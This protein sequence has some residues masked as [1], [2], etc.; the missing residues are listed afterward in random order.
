MGLLVC[1]QQGVLWKK[2]EGKNWNFR[3]FS[4]PTRPIWNT[5][6]PRS[7]FLTT[8]VLRTE[9]AAFRSLFS[10]SPA[11]MRTENFTAAAI[12]SVCLCPG[13]GVSFPQTTFEHYRRLNVVLCIEGREVVRGLDSLT[14]TCHTD[15]NLFPTTTT[16]FSFHLIPA[17]LFS[18]IYQHNN[19]CC[20]LFALHFITQL[21]TH[22]ARWYVCVRRRQTTTAVRRRNYLS[23]V[24]RSFAIKMRFGKTTGYK[25][26]S[27]SGKIVIEIAVVSKTLKR[28]VITPSC[29]LLVSIYR[30]FLWLMDK[31][32]MLCTWPTSEQMR[33]VTRVVTDGNL[34]ASC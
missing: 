10:R 6:A 9:P 32:G 11:W 26:T 16:E 30:Q 19:L 13:S 1:S 21:H 34:T 29:P 15:F 23:S 22:S 18:I 25:P 2:S 7:N 14:L 5:S 24:Q 3:L 8:F 31:S 27:F 12:V 28:S 20:G 33:V 17:C 4:S